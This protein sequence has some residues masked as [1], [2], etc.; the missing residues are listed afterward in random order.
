M[1]DIV[2]KRGAVAV[3][4]SALVAAILWFA[5]PQPSA[6]IEARYPSQVAG[7]QYEWPRDDCAM[8]GTQTSDGSYLFVLREASPGVCQWV[9]DVKGEKIVAQENA[10]REQLWN[11]LQTRV[12]T[13]AEMREVLGY[14]EF[15][16][17]PTGIPFNVEKKA[18]E[19]ADAFMTQLRLRTIVRSVPPAVQTVR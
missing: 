6:T 7:P 5:W 12:L 4:C 11:A 10:R 14:G 16:N 2:V 1:N 18:S 13:D 17:E 9:E 3:G 15:I 8:K 19:R